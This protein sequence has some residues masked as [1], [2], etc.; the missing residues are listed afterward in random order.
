MIR[1]VS[2]LVSGTAI[3]TLIAVA[4][5]AAP[6]DAASLGKY[7][8]GPVGGFTTNATGV[9][10]SVTFSAF[11]QGGGLTNVGSTLVGNPL[12]A[13]RASGWNG[14]ATDF[15]AFT[16]A[17]NAGKQLTIN[18]LKLDSA[19]FGGP[20]GLQIRSSLDSFDSVLASTGVGTGILGTSFASANLVLAGLTNLT[21]P[22]TFRIVGIGTPTGFP[23][24]RFLTLDNVELD[25]AVTAVPTPALL[26]A[27]MGLG[28]AAIRKRK[29]QNAEQLAEVES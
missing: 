1:Q 17:A 19:R 14:D 27:L 29:A 15:F 28:V 22:V 2:K 9:D 24:A 25:G 21:A 11:S 23:N 7:T 18:S 4:T 5:L 3:G 20:T 10:P 8:F 6:S 26:P 16:V 13:I 12:L